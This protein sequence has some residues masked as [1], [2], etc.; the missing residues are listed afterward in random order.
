MPFSVGAKNSMLDAIDPD[1]MSLHSGDP[2]AAGTDNELSGGGYA[3]AAC[4]F[5]AADASARALSTA[6]DFTCT[7]LTPVTY[8]GIWHNDVADVFLG[9]VALTGDQAANADGEYQVTTATSLTLTNS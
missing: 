1:L 9:S 2:G 3:R 6:V 5:A 7:A 4:T 8:V